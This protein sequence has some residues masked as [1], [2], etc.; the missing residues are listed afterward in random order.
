MKAKLSNSRIIDKKEPVSYIGMLQPH[1]ENHEIQD[2]SRYKNKFCHISFSN[3][4]QVYTV[5]IAPLFFWNTQIQLAAFGHR[6]LGAQLYEYIL[7]LSKYEIY[8]RA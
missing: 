2:A 7:P 1:G 4:L 3:T 6:A 5:N 8:T